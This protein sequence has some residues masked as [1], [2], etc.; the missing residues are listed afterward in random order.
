MNK[1]QKFTGFEFGLKEQPHFTL[2]AKVLE[3]QQSEKNSCKNQHPFLPKKGDCIFFK[4]ELKKS[5]D[6]RWG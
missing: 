2:E 5:C 4:G 6:A 1:L 3:V